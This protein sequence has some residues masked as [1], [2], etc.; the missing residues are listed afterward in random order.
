MV[1]SSVKIY[2][3]GVVD[4][5]ITIVCQADMFYIEHAQKIILS[6]RNYEPDLRD[7]FMYATNGFWAGSV[8]FYEYSDVIKNLAGKMME[9]SGKD[10]ERI[11]YENGSLEG[12]SPYHLTLAVYA[13]D[14]LGHTNIHFTMVD[15]ADLHG[16]RNAEFYIQ[17]V[18]IEIN[19]I[20]GNFLA[21][22][23]SNVK[24]EWSNQ[25]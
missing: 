12:K 25:V 15:N 10:T 8:E 20:G 18:P 11:D 7:Y 4:T 22:C 3:S 6:S 23:E 17:T 16:G 1:S 19:K 2:R 9:Y 21:C 14:G 5:K 24:K 13:T